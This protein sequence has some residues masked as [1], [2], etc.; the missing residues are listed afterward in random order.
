MTRS[1]AKVI[2]LRQFINNFNG[3][4]PVNLT[5]KD[6]FYLMSTDFWSGIPASFIWTA[7]PTA[8]F[9]L[10]TNTLLKVEKPS[11]TPFVRLWIQN[12]DSDQISFASTGNRTVR[13]YGYINYQ[14]FIPQNTGTKAGDDLCEE[15]NEI[16]EMKNIDSIYC[17]SGYYRESD[18]Q[19]DGFFMFVGGIR[20]DFDYKK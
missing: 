16:F 9:W 12:L 20:F 5:N 17:Y 4:T 13:R 14:V 8:N 15:I 6:D 19:D 10:G 7:I 2:L 1:E 3:Y 11:N 18:I